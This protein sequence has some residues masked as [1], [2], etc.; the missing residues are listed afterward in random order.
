[1]NVS[2]V[3]RKSSKLFQLNLSFLK[4]AAFMSTAALCTAV[5]RETAISAATK[6][7]PAGKR[8]ANLY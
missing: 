1:M 2:E 4:K 8:L 7:P 6:A 3:F 5:T